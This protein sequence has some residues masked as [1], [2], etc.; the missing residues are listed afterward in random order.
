[1][2]QEEVKIFTQITQDSALVL[3]KNAEL[4]D[5]VIPSL[6]QKLGISE[7][8][9]AE[10]EKTAE[11]KQAAL[12]SE[13]EKLADLWVD[14]G[15]LKSEKKAALVDMIVNDPSKGLPALEKIASQ[16]GAVQFGNASGEAV[17]D[18]VS[19]PIV[20]WATGTE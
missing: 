5:K 6:Q 13:M 15:I 10:L 2:N 3:T 16:A 11:Q 19:D 12:R 7:Q 20:R 14:R 17:L 18:Q 4:T 1:M 9:V 8:K